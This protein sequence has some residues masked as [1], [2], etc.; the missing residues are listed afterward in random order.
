MLTEDLMPTA[1]VLLDAVPARG[2]TALT[3]PEREVLP[4]PYAIAVPAEEPATG[5]IR[6]VVDGGFSEEI[7]PV[8]P[9]ADDIR[10]R[11]AYKGD[12]NDPGEVD[13]AVLAVPATSMSSALEEDT[14]AHA[15]A[16]PALGTPRDDNVVI[17]AGSDPPST[18][19]ATI[20]LG[21]TDP[22]GHALVPGHRHSLVPRPTEPVEA[23]GA[24]HRWA[25]AVGRG[26]AGP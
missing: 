12:T 1:R 7:H 5:A 18:Y 17:I 3:A 2:R 24:K 14:P 13:V 9:Q 25:R 8:N 21:P 15:R 19:E 11:E 23:L 26:E 22:R 10:G 16:L 6:G 20:R 4:D